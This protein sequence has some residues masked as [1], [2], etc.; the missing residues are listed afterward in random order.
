MCRTRKISLPFATPP[1]ATSMRAARVLLEAGADTEIPDD[2][3]RT[4]LLICARETGDVEMARLLLDHGANV[5]AADRFDDTPIVLSAWRGFEGQVNLFLDRGAETPIDGPRGAQLVEYSVKKGLPRLFAVLEANG[6]DFTSTTDTGWT[7]L[8]SA[9]LGGSAEITATLLDHGLEINGQDMYGYAPVHYAAKR[10]RD[11]VIEL[12]IS[13]GAFLEVVTMAG[14]T[15]WNIADKWHHDRDRGHPRGSGRTDFS[16]AVPRSEGQVP[17]PEAPRHGPRGLRRRDRV[18]LRRRAWLHHLLPRR[19]R[20]ILD[21]I[22]HGQG[23][24]LLDWLDHGNP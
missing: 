9:A 18:H 20:G 23:Y 22:V 6:A 19:R 5:N 13:K 16:P 15:P 10:G 14:D 1:F 8:H 12:L 7:K 4:P 17:R 21:D 24:R 2:Y 3:G 11:E